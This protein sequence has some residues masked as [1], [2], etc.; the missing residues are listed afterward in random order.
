MTTE[1]AIK[2]VQRQSPCPH[3]STDNGMG[4]GVTWAKCNDCGLTVRRSSLALAAE[5]SQRFDDAVE[6]LRTVAMAKEPKT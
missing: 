3:Y 2:I 1:E 4:D 5:S 6:H